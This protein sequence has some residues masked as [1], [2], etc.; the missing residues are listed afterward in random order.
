MKQKFKNLIILPVYEIWDIENSVVGSV[1]LGTHYKR[2][3]SV[4]IKK[5]NTHTLCTPISLWGLYSTDVLIEKD[6]KVGVLQYCL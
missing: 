4:S 3:F 2:Q 1:N 5:K 6:N